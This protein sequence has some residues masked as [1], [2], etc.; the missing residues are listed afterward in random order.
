MPKKHVKKFDYFD[1][2]VRMSDKSAQAAE[3]LLSLMEDF[4]AERLAGQIDDLHKVEHEADIIHHEIIRSLA[5]DFLTPI[6]REDLAHLA[7]E[8][9]EVTDYIEDV[10]QRMYMY[11]IQ[12]VPEHA[13]QIA[14]LICR[15]C[16][17]LRAALVAFPHFRKSDTLQKHIVEINRL[18]EEGDRFYMEG[19]RKLYTSK[20]DPV[21]ISAWA[22]V[23]IRLEKCCDACEHV[24]DA[25][26]SVVLKN[27]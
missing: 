11:N 14:R 13:L 15:C 23:Y 3:Q 6:E 25:M 24:A 12:S 17:E 21:E 10:A 22:A 8:L 2:F 27:T 16:T 4:D 26:E 19:N 18:E 20:G 9:D 1:A 5:R 7:A